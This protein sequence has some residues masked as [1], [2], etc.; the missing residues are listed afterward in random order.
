MPAEQEGGLKT[1]LHPMHALR[2]IKDIGQRR[3]NAAF[4]LEHWGSVGGQA[5]HPLELWGGS[6]AWLWPRASATRVA[7]GQPAGQV[8]RA[9]EVEQGIGEGFNLIH[10]QGLDLS[11]GGF[12][13]GAAATDRGTR[14][15]IKHL[16]C[17]RQSS[18]RSVQKLGLATWSFGI[19]AESLIN[20][21][22]DEPSANCLQQQSVSKFSPR[23]RE[24]FS[25]QGF[26]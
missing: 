2:R 12:A 13:Q 18:V 26:R 24:E 6:D 14:A 19:Q 3:L 20:R 23:D 8:G 11:G 21:S 10:W 22:A 5:R 25:S 4:R 7:G 16:Q 15:L 17:R 9:M 1:G